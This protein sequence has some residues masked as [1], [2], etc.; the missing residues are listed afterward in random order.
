MQK[1]PKTNRELRKFG[2]V[3]AGLSAVVAT[4]VWWR[5]GTVW[6]YLAAAAVV[7]LLTGLA[8]PAVLRPVEKGWMKLAEVLGTVMTFVVLVLAFFLVFT[9]FAVV[10]RLMGRR[11][12]TL[13]FDPKAA[14]Y[15]EPVGA[16]S[17][18]TRANKPY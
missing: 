6:P 11:P 5:G 4:I 9:P 3:M 10:M 14:S 13:G 16:D 2:G 12:L 8:A 15:W 17:P 18:Y 1:R 7:F